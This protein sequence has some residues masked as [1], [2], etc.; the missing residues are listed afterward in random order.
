MLMD[1]ECNNHDEVEK[2]KENKQP[3]PKKTNTQKRLIAGMI[4]TW[5]FG[6][7]L[8]STVPGIMVRYY[9]DNDI[10]EL[11]DEQTAIYEK[12]MA[13]EEF[14]DTFKTEFTK[15]SNDY[16][17]GLISY[18]EFDKK[19]KHL[20]SVE[21][22][23][24][25]LETSNNSLKAQ[26]E[27]INQKKEERREE[28]NSNIVSKV[29]IGAVGTGVAATM[30]FTIASMVYTNKEYA[31]DKRKRKAKKIKHQ[32]Y[33]TGPV[34]IDKKITYYAYDHKETKTPNPIEKGNN[35]SCNENCL[36]VRYYDSTT[37]TIRNTNGKDEEIEETLNK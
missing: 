22:A 11:N 2:I 21:Y 20:N 25:V 4:A 18:E 31:E 14:S 17:N 12:F 15:A 32:E 37:M 26:A 1:I 16:A 10:S 8:F 3:K 36:G 5:C 13:S 28:H 6:F 24:K 23:Q 33:E 34:L 29:S 9:Y 30:G 7:A 19:V 27:E 35:P